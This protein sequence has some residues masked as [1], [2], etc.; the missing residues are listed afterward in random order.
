MTTFRHDYAC[1]L[2][3][4]SCRVL[5]EI[6]DDIAIKIFY[7][8]F[9]EAYKDAR[10]GYLAGIVHFARNFSESL[11]NVHANPEDVDPQSRKNSVINIYLD[12]TNQQ[13][14]YYLQRRLYDVYKEYSQ[15]VLSDCNLPTK[16]DSIPI[17]FLKPIYGSYDTDFKHTMV[18]AFIMLFMFYLA[19]GLT[20][21]SIIYERKEGFWNR[22]LLAGVSTKEMMIAHV[23]INV[24]ILAVQLAEVVTLLTLVV[25]TDSRGSY[26]LVS[27]MIALLG[28]SGIFF[29][30]WCSCMCTT[31][32]EANLLMT[33]ISQPMIV[34]SGMF[35]PIEGMPWIV[36]MLSYA[37]PTTLSAIS[38]RHI[39]E[40]GYSITHP[41]VYVG[42]LVLI[43]WMVLCAILGLVT[44]ERRKYSR[45]T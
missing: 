42:F 24:S 21:A 22:T 43:G 40:K 33:G 5:S 44:L 9:D 8:N 29:G 37:T 39:I 31:F 3:K 10:K 18:P 38:V 25:S 2:H 41:S 14:T 12:Q 35:W 26:F 6:T 23:I 16:L 4:I 28:C 15:N 45:N 1:D 13:I 27:V 20:V 36:R 34:V 19:A 32:M 11:N 7:D 17:Q 30:L